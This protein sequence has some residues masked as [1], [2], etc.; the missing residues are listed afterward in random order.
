MIV[1][2]KLLNFTRQKIH[3]GV[4]FCEPVNPERDN[5]PE[6]LQI[7]KQP[8]DLGTILNKVYLDVYKN[9]G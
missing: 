8:M 5:C 1:C 3:Y 7:I 6:Y 9:A 2:S 4:L